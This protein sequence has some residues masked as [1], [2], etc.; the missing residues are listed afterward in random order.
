ME[1]NFCPFISSDNCKKDCTMSCRMYDF[2]EN[3]CSL[4]KKTKKI[5]ISEGCKIAIGFTLWSIVIAILGYLIIATFF[6]SN[7]SEFFDL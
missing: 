4:K 5:T 7:Y 2:D 3:C 6:V 1:E